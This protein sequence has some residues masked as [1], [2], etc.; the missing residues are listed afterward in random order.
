VK[1]EEDREAIARRLSNE[2]RRIQMQLETL[3]AS[4]TRIPRLIVN[5]EESIARLKQ[6]MSELRTVR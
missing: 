5:A 1:P 4:R 6:R 2:K 3:K